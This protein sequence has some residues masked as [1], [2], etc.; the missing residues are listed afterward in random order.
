M[1]GNAW[2]KTIQQVTWTTA[3]FGRTL[4]TVDKQKGRSER[5][6][7]EGLEMEVKKE[8]LCSASFCLLVLLFSAWGKEGKAAALISSALS[9]CCSPCD[10]GY[11]SGAP[12]SLCFPITTFTHC[13]SYRTHAHTASLI[14]ISAALF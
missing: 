14:Y 11:S 5:K 4:N 9:V 3:F 8:K 12:T 7:R 1:N 6:E 10:R 13:T 2:T